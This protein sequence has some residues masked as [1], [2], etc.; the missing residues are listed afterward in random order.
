MP[1]L[2]GKRKSSYH[3]ADKSAWRIQSMF[4]RVD[5][6][7]QE[8]PSFNLK[9]EAHINTMIGGIMTIIILVLTVIYASTKIVQLINK[10]DP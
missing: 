10:E 8:L 5:V 1:L 4:R 7:G 2:F 6:Y 3:S 9:G